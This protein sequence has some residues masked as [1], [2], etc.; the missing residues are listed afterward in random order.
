MR[1]SERRDKVDDLTAQFTRGLLDLARK[2]KID[3]AYVGKRPSKTDEVIAV[4][5]EDLQVAEK[6]MMK[7]GEL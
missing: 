3:F 4:L 2:E 1:R 7:E 5:R 6:L